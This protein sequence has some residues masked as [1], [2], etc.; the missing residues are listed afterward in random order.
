MTLM[1]HAI[2]F[3]W[4][5]LTVFVLFPDVV[6]NLFPEQVDTLLESL[7]PLLKRLSFSWKDWQQHKLS[8]AKLWI[9][10]QT[11]LIPV[12]IFFL[13]HPSLFSSLFMN[14]IWCLHTDAIVW[15]FT[16]IEEYESP[17]LIQSLLIRCKSPFL[18]VYAL[19]FDC[20]IHALCNTIV[21]GL[22]VWG[23]ASTFW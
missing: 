14:G 6:D 18:T 23:L 8:P 9:N 10:P 16:I 2:V 19:I 12:I 3:S 4:F 5:W 7:T 22:V 21:S 17:Y 1:T 13:P 20:L 15:A 11:L